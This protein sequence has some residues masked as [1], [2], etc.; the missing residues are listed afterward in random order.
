MSQ[1]Q[2][3][4]IDMHLK[5]A[6]RHAPDADL[7]P[8]ARLDEAILLAARAQ[9]KADAAASNAVAPGASQAP[10]G[11]LDRLRAWWQA[12]M[13]MPALGVLVMT[14]VVLGMW[15]GQEL[16]SP[17]VERDPP[18]APTPSAPSVAARPAQDMAS[19]VQASPPVVADASTAATTPRPMESGP[20]PPPTPAPAPAPPPK[21]KPTQQATPPSRAVP[22]QRNA[23]A[24]DVETQAGRRV[25]T[26]PKKMRE[27]APELT[28]EPTQTQVSETTQAHAATKRA[29]AKSPGPAPSPSP[30]PATAPASNTSAAPQT[31]FMEAQGA[32]RPMADANSQTRVRSQR[33]STASALAPEQFA[34]PATL[35]AFRQFLSADRDAA[36]AVTLWQARR[37]QSQ[38]SLP[39]EPEVRAWV[40]RIHA[41]S[42]GRWQLSP[43]AAPTAA[44]GDAV[45]LS[46]AGAVVATIVVEDDAIHWIEATGQRWKAHLQGS[47]A[48]SLRLR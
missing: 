25:D 42:Q 33:D 15:R 43:S 13:A 44:T 32:S 19:T 27:Q 7:M 22:S 6:L 1:P 39:L 46:R 41:A 10:P 5:T 9:A 28:S 47:A 20:T 8:S 30:S 3:P 48:D 38:Q 37:S 17:R 29:D 40:E 35:T 31:T 23:P 34:A 18:Q 21:P 36:P 11:W 14:T 24:Q 45:E 26:P 4:P 16:P 12:P 2:K